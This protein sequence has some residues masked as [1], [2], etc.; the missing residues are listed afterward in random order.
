MNNDQFGV[1][2][3]GIGDLNGDRVNDI[4]VGALVDNAQGP[5]AGTLHILY[6]NRDGST[7]DSFEINAIDVAMHRTQFG[8]SVANI[9]DLDKDGINDL[10]VGS[11][12]GQV[13]PDRFDQTGTID[14]IFMDS[15]A[16]G[17]EIFRPDTDSRHT[18]DLDAV[19][20]NFGSGNSKCRRPE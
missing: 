1:S 13:T 2:V 16:S 19:G 11:L 9:G 18:T 10:A 3:V 4:A 8:F 7:N 6:L 17:V 5:E 15:Q 20:T 14:I 12:R